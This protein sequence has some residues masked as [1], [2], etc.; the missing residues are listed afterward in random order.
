MEPYLIHSYHQ[1]V[2]FNH[3][4]T[5]N[6][7]ILGMDILLD[8]KMNAWLMEVNANPS[9]NMFLEK[10]MPENS[11]IEPEK[12]LSELDKF[13]KTKVAADAIRIV[14]GHGTEEFEGT[15]QQVLPEEDGS[16]D[17]YYIWN[18]A[19]SLF[20]MMVSQGKQ[21][22]AVS[23]FQFSRLSRVPDFAKVNQFFKADLDICFKNM[24]RKHDTQA[25]DLHAFFDAIEQLSQKIYKD[26]EDIETSLDYFLDAA[27]AYFEEQ[28]NKQEK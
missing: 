10:D 28:A 3:E 4:K 2:N 21:S 14:T 22:E 27:V 7:Q 11:L 12:I 19:L 23:N 24:A 6:F 25:L 20:E 1:K 5:K 17:N 8:K 13:V 15:Y 18:R 26:E 9:L 16:L